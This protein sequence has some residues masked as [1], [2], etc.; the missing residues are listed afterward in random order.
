MKIH[1]SPRHLKL[2]E[3]MEQQA[4]ARFHSLSEITE[5]ILI[6][7]IVLS[8]DD[9]ADPSQRF[10]VSARL[11]IAGPDIHAEDHSSDLYIAMDSVVSKLARQ[12]RKRKTR[13]TDKR[14]SIIQ[15]SMERSRL[16]EKAA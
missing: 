7:H 3:S 9:V 6:A 1:L 5:G 10:G 4:I 13:M 16:E 11:S 2:T 8:V 14:R 15:R 12:L